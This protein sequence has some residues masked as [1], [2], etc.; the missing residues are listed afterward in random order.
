MKNAVGSIIVR[1]TGE[2]KHGNNLVAIVGI[3]AVPDGHPF[4]EKDGLQFPVLIESDSAPT[5][6]HND[7][8]RGLGLGDLLTEPIWHLPQYRV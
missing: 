2:V 1:P 3:V 4:L 8:A 5:A 7:L 6:N